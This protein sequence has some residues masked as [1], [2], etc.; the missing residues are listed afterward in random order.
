MVQGRS[1]AS[2]GSRVVPSLTKEELKEIDRQ[3]KVFD[4]EQVKTEM[5]FVEENF[6]IFKKVTPLIIERLERLDQIPAKLSFMF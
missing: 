4:E 5:Q 6:D 2:E 3:I 1:E